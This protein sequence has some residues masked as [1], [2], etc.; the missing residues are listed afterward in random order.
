MVEETRI[1]ENSL[2][3]GSKKIEGNENQSVVVQRR[4][5]RAKKK[6]LEG[7]KIKSHMLTY[8][9]PCPKKA[10][11]P[12]EKYKILN[13]ILKKNIAKGDIVTCEKTK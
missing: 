13:K 10:L 9:R 7:Q 2:G 8:L 3:D 12:Y 6:L 11:N 4:A 5:I 1:L